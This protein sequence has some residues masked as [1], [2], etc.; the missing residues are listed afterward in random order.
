MKLQ[1]KET[2]IIRKKVRE[3]LKHGVKILGNYENQY[4]LI[5]VW[6]RNN[7]KTYSIV[8]TSGQR[9]KGTF[10]SIEIKEEGVSQKGGYFMR[11]L[12]D[13]DN[14]LTD[15]S[16]FKLSSTFTKETATEAEK[17]LFTKNYLNSKVDQNLTKEKFSKHAYK[18]ESVEW[19]NDIKT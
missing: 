10:K 3:D 4:D 11:I 9:F 16:F 8:A 14:N 12:F 7:D 18:P 17:D 15:I 2:N 6:T 1:K 19:M 5:R 13:A